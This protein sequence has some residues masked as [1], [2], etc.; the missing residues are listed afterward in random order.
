MRNEQAERVEINR[1]DGR[2]RKAIRSFEGRPLDKKKIPA[3]AA[4]AYKTGGWIARSG[5]AVGD[6]VS[7]R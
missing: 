6:E 2:I 5:L 1:L 3:T 4:A 7:S